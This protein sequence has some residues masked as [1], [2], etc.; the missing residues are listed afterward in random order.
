MDPVF[1]W[2]KPDKIPAQAEFQKPDHLFIGLFLWLQIPCNHLPNQTLGHN[3]D[4]LVKFS[5]FFEKRL[6]QHMKNNKYS[7]RIFL[8][9]VN[10]VNPV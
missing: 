4:N 5:P 9:L 7:I 1:A 3:L 2:I 10:L 8:N 6:S